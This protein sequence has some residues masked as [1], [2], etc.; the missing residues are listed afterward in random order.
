MSPIFV[1][2]NELLNHLAAT[3][4]KAARTV[5]R[6]KRKGIPPRTKKWLAV[7]GKVHEGRGGYWLTLD[8]RDYEITAKLAAEI[9]TWQQ[10]TASVELANRKLRAMNKRASLRGKPKAS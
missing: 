10:L 9:T 4:N 2:M 6:W 7:N 3:Q 1:A 5:R 8:R